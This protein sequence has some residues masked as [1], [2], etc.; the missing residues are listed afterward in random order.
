MLN[1]FHTPRKV[2]GSIMKKMPLKTKAVTSRWLIRSLAMRA[3]LLSTIV[4]S[5]TALIPTP[6]PQPAHGGRGCCFQD[7]DAGADPAPGL[8]GHGRARGTW[9]RHPQAV[10]NCW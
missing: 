6:S 5:V 3:A 4:N 7:E 10:D 1:R 9:C 2:P 8:R